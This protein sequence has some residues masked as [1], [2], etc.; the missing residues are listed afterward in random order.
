VGKAPRI[1]VTVETQTEDLF[2]I[3]RKGC[4]EAQRRV[5]VRKVV[6]VD[7]R[8]KGGRHLVTVEPLMEDKPH[9]KKKEKMDK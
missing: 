3:L 1:T 4:D 8:R 9:G 7:Y 5:G 6:P 2:H